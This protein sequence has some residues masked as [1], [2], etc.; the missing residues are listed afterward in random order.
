M[1]AAYQELFIKPS[2]FMF[3]FLQLLFTLVHINV[4]FLRH[5]RRCPTPQD[6][7]ICKETEQ[8]DK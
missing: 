7:G 3:N 6:L 8:S 2:V 5:L 1:M 4:T